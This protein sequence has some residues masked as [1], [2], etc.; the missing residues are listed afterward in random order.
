[1]ADIHKMRSRGT[2]LGNFSLESFTKDARSANWD[3]ERGIVRTIKKNYKPDRSYRR[4]QRNMTFL[5]K[6]IRLNFPN[7]NTKAGYVD[8]LRKWLL[9]VYPEERHAIIQKTMVLTTAEYGKRRDQSLKSR[10]EKLKNISTISVTTIKKFVKDLQTDDSLEA[11]ILLL[12]LSTG[13][14]KIEILSICDRPQ[15]DK[16]GYIVFQALAKKLENGSYIVPFYF[17]DFEELL[18]RWDK[19][20][21]K[22]PQHLSNVAVAQI[23]NQKIS[24]VIKTYLNITAGSH[25]ARKIYTAY[26]MFKDK[27]SNWNDIIYINQI[28]VH[29]P[30][31]MD[32]A[33]NYS[34]LRIGEVDDLKG[35]EKKASKTLERMRETVKK[36]KEEE[37]KITHKVLKEHG[38]G[39][40]SICKY[41]PLVETS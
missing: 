27:P 37:I 38:F 29:A 6:L 36:L 2:E 22:V 28:L 20:R 21:A 30:G 33:L 10:G 24:D 35:L 12:C 23:Y 41:L 17:L 8:D 32:S 18:T 19:V 25:L 13:R 1:M 31:N 9:E 4:L 26:S 7:I 39:S 34:T 15:V 16:P 11:N 40:G 5:K 3:L 14:R